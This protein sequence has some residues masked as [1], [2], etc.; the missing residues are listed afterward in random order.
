[1]AVWRFLTRF[2]LFNES[3]GSFL[4][5]TGIYTYWVGK[6][7]FIIYTWDT[8]ARHDIWWGSKHTRRYDW[9]YELNFIK[10]KTDQKSTGG[11]VFML[12]GALI[13]HLSKLQS[14][15]VLLT[16]ET[17]YI[18]MYKIWKKAIWLGYL[19]VKLKFRNKSTLITLYTDNK[20]SITLSNNL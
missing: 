18:T 9:V 17:E 15:V 11:Y 2:G 12:I 16:Y 4:H 20:S 10:S 3:I 7:C 14:I 8:R 1:M 6:T 5:Q 13:N 19:L